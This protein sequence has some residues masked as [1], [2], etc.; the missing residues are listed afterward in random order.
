MLVLEIAAGI[1][2][3]GVAL[4]YWEI[5]WRLA[6][7]GVLAALP[8]AG[9]ITMYVL[10]PQLFWVLAEV[11]GVCFVGCIIFGAVAGFMGWEIE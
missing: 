1:V 11:F 7:L 10:R 2:L 5:V 9:L 4:L 8:I 3:G 6:V